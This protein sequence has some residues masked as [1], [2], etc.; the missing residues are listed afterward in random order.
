[1][2]GSIRVHIFERIASLPVSGVI[3]S[4][5]WEALS[6]TD[7]NGDGHVDIVMANGGNPSNAIAASDNLTTIFTSDANFYFQLL[8]NKNISPTGWVNDWVFLNNS[9][10]QNYIIGIDHGRE[11]AHDPKYWS[12][13]EI[14]QISGNTLLDVTNLSPTDVVGFWHNSSST[15]DLNGDG[16]QDF[17]VARMDTKSFSVFY[18]DKSE[19]IKDVTDLVLGTDNT[20]NT[21]GATNSV[22]STGAALVIDVGADKQNDFILLPYTNDW[23]NGVYA[24]IF[25]YSNGQYAKEISFDATHGIDFVLPDGWGYSYAQV[26]D[27]NNDGRQDFI[28]LAESPSV[29][30]SGQWAFVSFIQQADGTFKVTKAFPDQPILT[31]SEQ[32]IMNWAGGSWVWSDNKFQLIDVNG[33][34]ILDLFWGSWFNGV[35]TDLKSSL[36]FG[37]GSGHFSRDDVKASSLFQGVTWNGT[38]RTFIADFNGDNIGDL[39]VLQSTWNTPQGEITPIVFLNYL[40]PSN[41]N[42]PGTSKGDFLTGFNAV[43]WGGPGDDTITGTSGSNTSTYSGALNQYTITNK[44]G[45]FTVTDGSSGRDGTDTLTNIQQIQ[46]ADYS[47]N[48]TMKTEAAKLPSATVNSIVELY[49]AYFARTPDASGLS[50]WINKAAGGESLTDIAKEFYNAGVQFSSLTGYSANMANN[51]FTKIVYS[52]VLGRTGATAPNADELGYWDNRIKTGLTTK[53]G[54]I[55]KMLSDAHSFAGDPKWGWVPK[56]LDNKIE[57]GYKAA[58]TYGLDYNSPTDAITQGMAIAGAVTPTDT[59]AAVGLIGVAGHVFL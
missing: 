1:M 24:E 50:Y 2:G 41:V 27:L 8:K 19:I 4:V 35:P 47:I 45:V 40:V 13:M 44:S 15:G 9:N 6:V 32:Q 25:R 48:T 43:F 38:A 22:G 37:D 56:L 21:W 42:V 58:V 39:L 54:L 28:A 46:F 7:V 59:S 51:D 53:E 57:V 18:G 26:K 17:V 16:I 14:F 34:G 20:F 30:S 12:K 52:N 49:V 31:N 23:K 55:Q 3:V 29:A 5:N 33:D 36:F 11:I 10:G